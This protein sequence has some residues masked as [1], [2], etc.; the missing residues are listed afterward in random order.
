VNFNRERSLLFRRM[1]KD[2]VKA[3]QESK[4]ILAGGAITSLF[5][6]TR[7]S[8][9]DLYFRDKE[10][11]EKCDKF[12]QGKGKREFVTDRS[13]TY[14]VAKQKI[15]YQ[16]II[17]LEKLSGEPAEIFTKFDF[18]I[19]MGA[20][21]FS[22]NEFVF[23]EEFWKHLS[24]RRLVF[25]G[26]TLYPIVSMMRSHKYARRGFVISGIDIMKIALSVQALRIDTF[27]DLKDQLMGIDTAFL[28]DL[29]DRFTEDAEAEKKYEL[30]IFIGILDKFL[31]EQYEKLGT[32][33]EEDSN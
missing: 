2:V 3:L 16:M 13:V 4:V 22:T 9:W 19:C 25:N 17:Y 8:D 6:S 23:H 18:T 24:Q 26:S 29:T 20:F 33:E 28:K 14:S 31:D 1:G 30:D 32:A 11:L 12:F 27:A 10:G 15:P 5:T 7:I 21:D